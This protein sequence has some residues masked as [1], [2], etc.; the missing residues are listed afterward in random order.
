MYRQRVNQQLWERELRLQEDC[1]YRLRWALEDTQRRLDDANQR[2]NTANKETDV[3]RDRSGGPDLSVPPSLL[4]PASG[5]GRGSEAPKLPPAPSGPLVEPGR[6]FN[7]SGS[8]PG[9]SPSGKS[10]TSVVPPELRGPTVSPAGLVESAANPLRLSER[11]NP[12]AEVEQIILNPG[13]T[14]ALAGDGK[15]TED[16]LNVVIEQRDPHDATVLAPGDVSIVVVDPALEGREARIARWNFDSDEVAKHIRRNRDGG[17]LQFELPWP[18]PPAHSDLRLFVRFT[19]YDGR[20]LEANLPIDVQLAKTD[21]A[22]SASSG[23]A[24][25]KSASKL[26]NNDS[27]SPGDD[28]DA[29]PADSSKTAAATKKRSVYESGDADPQS[30]AADD[31][32]REAKRNRPGW[33]PYR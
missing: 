15:S 4:G 25:K 29:V 23:N 18:T 24:W 8:S 33:S 1:I 20:R 17:T 12:D 30:S 16:R 2:L 19:T 21:S 26:I 28:T 10:G 5:G 32:P 31:A 13:L 6:E 27:A 22:G 11:L 7:P 9:P 3:L 14:G